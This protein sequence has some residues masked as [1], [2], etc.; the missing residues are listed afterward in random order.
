MYNNSD[1]IKLTDYT[2]QESFG[3]R[4]FQISNWLRENLAIRCHLI[5]SY[6][7]NHFV[8]LLSGLCDKNRDYL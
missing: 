3:W 4:V 8:V 2:S 6:R 1:I 5:Q 7:E